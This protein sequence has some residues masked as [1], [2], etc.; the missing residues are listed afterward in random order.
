MFKNWIAMAMRRKLSGKTE[1][2][3]K[4]ISS[5]DILKISIIHF[6]KKVSPSK[7]E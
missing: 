2:N 3:L 1:K 7:H 6:A 5:H 4:F